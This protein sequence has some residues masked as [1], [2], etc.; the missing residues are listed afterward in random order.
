MPLS[1]GLAGSISA[2][3]TPGLAGAGPRV[4]AFG[5][6]IGTSCSSKPPYELRLSSFLIEA[7]ISFHDTSNFET[8]S[9]SRTLTTSS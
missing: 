9:S 1:V 2:A 3:I 5:M 7:S 6:F 4:P 8:P